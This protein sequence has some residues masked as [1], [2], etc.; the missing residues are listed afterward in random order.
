MNICYNRDE[1][2][3]GCFWHSMYTMKQSNFDPPMYQQALIWIR[4]VNYLASR[5]CLAGELH[6]ECIPTTCH[7]GIKKLTSKCCTI[8]SK[9]HHVPLFL[10]RC[11]S[12]LLRLDVANT[13]VSD[14]SFQG[15]T[16]LRNRNTQNQK[17][18]S[19]M[20]QWH[21]CPR[22]C[23]LCL[24]KGLPFTDL[25]RGGRVGLM[26]IVLE[27]I[28]DFYAFLPAKNWETAVQHCHL[29]RKVQAG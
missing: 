2:I 13:S 10:P 16:D 28:K 1:D 4:L 17:I 29:Q 5:Q 3:R 8:W 19:K 23:L 7:R 9:W 26:L 21:W 15:S 14:Q 18:D 25:I 6:S 24:N 20:K 12:C 11:S 27:T 22:S